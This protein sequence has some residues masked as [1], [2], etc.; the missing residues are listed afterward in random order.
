MAAL[1][2]PGV[3]AV[4]TGLLVGAGPVLVMDRVGTALREGKGSTGVR[5]ARAR[6][7]LGAGQVALATV[8]LIG[9]GLMPRSFAGLMA[10]EAE[11]P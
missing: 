9:S 7:G 3:V 5:G 6:A 8:L 10:V 2:L 4:I 1:D 11:A